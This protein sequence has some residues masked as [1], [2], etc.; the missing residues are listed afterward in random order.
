MGDDKGPPVAPAAPRKIAIV[1]AVADSVPPRYLSGAINCAHDF[2][3]WARLQGYETTLVTDEDDPVTMMVLRAAIDTALKGPAGEP[4]KTEPIGRII[5]YFAGHG[6]IRELEEGLWLLSDWRQEMR[7]VAVEGLRRRLSMYAPNQVS[8]IS[9]ACRSLPADVAQADLA[10][11]PVLGAGPL[12]ASG[13]VQ[14]DKFVAAQDGADAFMIPGED[15]DDDRCLFS[16]VLIEGLWGLPGLTCGPFSKVEPTRVTSSSLATYLEAEVA[17][18]AHDYAIKVAPA[19]SP[20][21]REAENYYFTSPSPNPPPAFPPWPPKGALAAMGAGAAAEPLDAADEEDDG[22]L[23]LGDLRRAR[24]GGFGGV[25]AGLQRGFVAGGDFAATDDLFS[26]FGFTGANRG[27][28]RRHD[29][30]DEPAPAPSLFDQ[31]QG[32]RPPGPETGVRTGL[33]ATGGDVARLW[34]GASAVATPQSASSWRFDDPGGNYTLHL[35]APLLVE[36]TDGRYA[37]VVAVADHFAA[38]ARD[39][40]GVTGL[41]Y[42]DP[43]APHDSAARTEEALAKLDAGALRSDEATDLA[44]YLREFKHAD[45]VLG[46]I[47]AYLYDAIGDVE[48]IRRM[49]GFY[50]Q[51]GEA[52]PY[53]IALLAGLRGQ[54]AADG[55]FRVD[56]PAVAGRQPR[57]AAEKARPWTCSPVPELKDAMVAGLWPWMRQGWTFLDDPSDVGSPLILPGLVELRSGLMRSRFA[58]LEHDQAMALAQIAMLQPLG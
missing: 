55:V 32:L 20:A 14:I 15:P 11:D 53:D 38:L 26:S 17:A 10:P 3:D 47:S 34:I 33:A 50:A 18:R 6:L 29:D 19:L 58:T 25:L 35:P 48:S 12:P 43:Y 56:V 30:D 39:A 57:T 1:I 21:F 54:Q 5:V 7:A 27:P 36:F 2:A 46:V 49:A 8:I 41:V 4:P 28:R 40:F 13:S 31:L 42:H 22:L 23:D 24:G 44:A 37:A 51:Y 52:I 45:P 16:G 9:D